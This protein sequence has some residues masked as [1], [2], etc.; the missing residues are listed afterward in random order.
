MAAPHDEIMTA[1]EGKKEDA[2]Q[3]DE[4]TFNEKA[5]AA[6]PAGGDL[7]AQ[8]LAQYGGERRQLTDTDSESVRKT[9]SGLRGDGTDRPD[10][11]VPHARVLLHLLLPATRQVFHLFWCRVRPQGG[12]PPPVSCP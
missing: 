12:C 11:H 1:Q 8:W 9:V 10:R 7:G 2:F 4:E 6:H 3:H 5:N